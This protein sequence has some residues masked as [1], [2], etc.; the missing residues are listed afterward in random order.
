MRILKHLTTWLLLLTIFPAGGTVSAKVASGHQNLGW[1][2]HQVETTSNQL[3]HQAKIDYS[4]GEASGSPVATKRGARGASGDL[5][6]AS[7]KRYSGNSTGSSASGGD[8]RASMHPKTKQA[9]DGVQKPSRTHGHCCEIDAINKALN[10]G[11]NVR[12]AK[13]GPVRLNES[14]RTI[15]AC[16][17]CREV[18]KTLGVE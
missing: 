16:S 7:G 2:G 11:D 10:A 18:K 15:G 12:G 17:T 8:A 1:T 14:G 3:W 9:L 13:M 5:T 6:T 4:Y